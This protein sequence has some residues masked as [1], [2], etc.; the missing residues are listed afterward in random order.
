MTAGEPFTSLPAW[1]FHANSGFGVPLADTPAPV[2]AAS[3]RNIAAP[4]S[5]SGAELV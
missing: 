4:V 1:N 3:T 2:R 5:C